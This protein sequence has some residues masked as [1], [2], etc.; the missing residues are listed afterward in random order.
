MK[1]LECN[2]LAKPI[3]LKT[4]YDGKGYTIYKIYCSKKCYKKYINWINNRNKITLDLST[5]V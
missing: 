1:C 4:F 3:K 5:I 2:K